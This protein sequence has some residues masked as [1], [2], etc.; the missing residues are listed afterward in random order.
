M[1]EARRVSA[2]IMVDY[3][4]SFTRTDCFVLSLRE[5]LQKRQASLEEKQ[6]HTYEIYIKIWS[7]YGCVGDDSRHFMVSG[8]GYGG[9]QLLKKMKR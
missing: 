8:R 9:A 1:N 4:Y 6:I 2:R 5:V 7:E 3:G